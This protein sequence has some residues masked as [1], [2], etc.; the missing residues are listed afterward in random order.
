MAISVTAPA[1]ILHEVGHKLIALSYGLQATF[2][3]HYLGL[4]IGLMLKLLGSPILFFIPAY[5][6][7]SGSAGHLPNALIAFAGPLINLILWFVSK[8]VLMNSKGLSKDWKRILLVTR[9]INGFLFIINMIPVPGFDGFHVI[10]SIWQ[11]LN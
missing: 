1:I 4:G 6:A 5:V 7:T 9:K 8:L 2:S 11:A 10:T 3:A